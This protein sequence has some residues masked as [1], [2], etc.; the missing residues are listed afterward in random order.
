MEWSR[1]S[2]SSKLVFPIARLTDLVVIASN[3]SREGIVASAD[4]DCG[5]LR[6]FGEY[7][8]RSQWR[9]VRA[10]RSEEP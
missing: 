1:L 7:I 6:A 4:T 9:F 8:M 10:C 5:I 2:D 3:G